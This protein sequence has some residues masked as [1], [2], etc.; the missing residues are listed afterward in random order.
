M[1]RI[2]LLCIAIFF[3]LGKSIAQIPLNVSLF[4]QGTAIP[5]TKL[6][7]NPIHP[8]IQIGT[9]FDYRKTDHTRWFQTA[10]IRY[11]YHGHLAHGFGLT[12]DLGWEYKTAFGLAPAALLG[13]G[14]MRT[15]SPA[16]VFVLKNG[17]YEG[18]RDPGNNRFTAALSLDIGWY[19]SP[20]ESTGT[21]IFLRYESW[22]QYPFSPG[23]IPLMA[24]INLH[25][26]TSFNIK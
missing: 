25:V 4:N 22:I 16:E 5:Y 19:L 10:N 15:Y 21:R 23:F 9:E 11:F 13:I 6:L 12:T 2:V 17:T 7:T 18:G 20:E 1:N 14:Y 24:H 26:G 8:G 3:G